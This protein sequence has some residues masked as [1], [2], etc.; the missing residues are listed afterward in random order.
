MSKQEIID[1][2]AM[3]NKVFSNIKCSDI[4][5]GNEVIDAWNKTVEKIYNYG[6]KLAGH[7][8]IVDIKNGV[9]LIET[10][11]PGWTQ[12]L[13]NNKAFILKGLK[14]LVKD[15]EIRNLVFRVKGDAK[16][17][18][19]DYNT[20]LAKRREEMLKNTEKDEE[21]LKKKGFKYQKSQEEVPE[22]VKKMFDGIFEEA[23][24]RDNTVDQSK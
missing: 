24:K 19:D 13:Q 7:S 5:K 2:S 14:M 3:I 11:H 17:L 23:K 8:H 18:G 9:L 20:Y 16:G 15:I 4:E 1:T 22:E 6:P 21:E 10:D 12:I